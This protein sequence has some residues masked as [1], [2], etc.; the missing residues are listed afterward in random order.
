MNTQDSFYLSGQP[1]T[2]TCYLN[3][4]HFLKRAG[5]GFGM[6]GLAGLL[7]QLGL[8]AWE[9]TPAGNL[10]GPLQSRP[11]HFPPKARAVVWCFMYGGPSSID[12]F[13]A[14]PELD[15][16]HGK[17][18]GKGEVMTFSGRLGP[19][20]RSPF[21]FKPY[22]Q[23]GQPVSDVYSHIARHVD[24]IAFLRSCHVETNVH[25]QALFQVNTGLTRLGFPS[26]G[27]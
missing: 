18:F 14:K 2:R 10:A 22:G 9:K 15:R 7:D 5:G 27:S 1:H 3:R 24:D 26:A 23:C 16:S 8:L 12:L 4:R 6:L 17:Q 11:T 13:D 20:M 21:T 19:L 25:D